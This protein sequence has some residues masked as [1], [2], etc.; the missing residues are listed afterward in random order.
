MTY[1]DLPIGLTPRRGAEFHLIRWTRG[2]DEWTAETIIAV[3][4]SS[5]LSEWIVDHHGSRVR[6]SRQEWLRYLP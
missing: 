5:T 6:L 3:Y 4:I 1:I 2:R